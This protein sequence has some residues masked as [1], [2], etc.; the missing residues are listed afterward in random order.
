M[1]SQVLPCSKEVLSF[2]TCL[3]LKIFEPN[4]ILE[5]HQFLECIHKESLSLGLRVRV[6]K[7]IESFHA[8]KDKYPAIQT[9]E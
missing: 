5:K 9:Q 7:K 3:Q 8:G 6:I 4:C 2:E 1:K